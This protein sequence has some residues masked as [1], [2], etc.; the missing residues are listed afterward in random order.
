MNEFNRG[1]LE[2]SMTINYQAAMRLQELIW[3]EATYAKTG[4][5]EAGLKPGRVVSK[6]M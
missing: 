4:G 5:A 6:K 1:L 3:P 2:R